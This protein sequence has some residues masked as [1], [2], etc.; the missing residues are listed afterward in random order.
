MAEEAKTN[1][2]APK[3]GSDEYNQAM[4]AK[5][6]ATKPGAEP[7][8]DGRDPA[9][10]VPM[11]KDGDAKFY[12]AKTGA[13]NWEAHAKELS[14]K[15]SQKGGKTE[16]KKEGEKPSE[17]DVDKPSDEA[18]KSVFDLAGLKVEDLAD[19]IRST[20]T[21]SPEARAALVKV[22]IANELIDEHVELIN[23][24]L[25]ANTEKAITYAGGK[26]AWE[27]MNKWASQ[28]LDEAAKGQL[29][30]LLRGTP[31]EWEL[32]IDGLRTKMKS[33]LPGSKEGKLING[34]N[35]A[36]GGDAGFAS[37]AAMVQA[38]NDP[39]Y[40]TDANYRHQV[41]RRIQASKYSDDDNA[42]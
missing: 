41:Q 42:A 37:R 23:F 3:P 8:D 40:Q 9:P 17:A 36:P 26:D 24:K 14:F 4:T 6:Q 19:Q 38:I 31:A 30:K 27:A 10:I 34:G 15:L 25:A 16:A 39:R 11:P 7:E 12:D 13:Y 28:N 21:I 18:P 2:E 32:A 33:A 35:N 29:N 20:Q 22:G 5:F 1:Q